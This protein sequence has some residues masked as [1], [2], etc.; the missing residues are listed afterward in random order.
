MS[1]LPNADPT[2]AAPPPRSAGGPS[3]GAIGVVVVLLGGLG[4]GLSKKNAA[5]AAVVAEAAAAPLPTAE[6]VSAARARKQPAFLAGLGSQDAAGRRRMVVR[7]A[8]SEDCA[9]ETL[10]TLEGTGVTTNEKETLRHAAGGAIV[11]R[12]LVGTRDGVKMDPVPLVFAANMLGQYGADSLEGR[13]PV[14]V[15]DALASPSS[16]RGDL[17]TTEGTIAE[18][19]PMDPLSDVVLVTDDVHVLHVLSP[20]ETSHVG[21]GNKVSVRGAV[22]QVYEFPNARGTTVRSLLLIGEVH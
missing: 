19:N 18:I 5:D 22:A 21:A 4:I 17:V 7:C 11:A 9:D 10:T 1:E 14:S 15:V 12:A 6:D 13:P 16:H 20:F 2:P 8:G 3:W